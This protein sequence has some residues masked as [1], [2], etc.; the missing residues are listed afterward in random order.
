M[1][2]VK[3]LVAF[4]DDAILRWEGLAL[5]GLIAIMT[6]IVFAQVVFRYLLS[7]PLVWSEELARYL[8]VWVTMIGSAMAVRMGLHYGLDILVK[9]LPRALAAFAGMLGSA[10]IAAIA[11]TLIWQGLK[12]SAIATRHFA[13]SMEISMAWFYSAL[14]IGGLLMLWHLA[15]RMIASGIGAS[16]IT[17][18]G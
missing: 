4:V 17:S 6:A 13:S 1:R 2:S 12:E 14:P 3:A 15:A 18:H 7:S 9:P 11:I 10:I 16:P 8:F 5:A